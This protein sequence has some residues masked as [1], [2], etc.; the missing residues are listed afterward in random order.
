MPSLIAV[1]P[2]PEGAPRLAVRVG[3]VLQ[4]NATGARITGGDAAVELLGAF[5]EAVAAGGQTLRAEGSPSHV[6]VRARA[7]G[8]A[9][10]EVM[11]GDPWGQATA[12]TYGIDV[13]A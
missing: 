7:A 6:L 13:T 8:A 4:F 9:E 11:S 10:I 12:Q 3:D 1:Q 2:H 5:G